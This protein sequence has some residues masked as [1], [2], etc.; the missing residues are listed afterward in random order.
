MSRKTIGIIV[1]LMAVV[2]TFLQEQF[3]L[4]LD[5]A[6]VAAG[7]GAVITYIFFE[8]KLDIKAAAAQPG[9][10]KDPKFW[11]TF[12][13]AALAGVEAQFHLGLPIEA[14]VS[15]ATLLVGLLFGQKFKKLKP[16]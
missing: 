11:I 1:A 12:I 6:A 7:I 4:S 3:G 5:P 14:I 9:K 16:Y 13:S 2:L 10:W 8:F 15:I